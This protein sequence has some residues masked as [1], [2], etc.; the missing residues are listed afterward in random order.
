LEPE[1]DYSSYYY[2]NRRFLDAKE[3]MDIGA[4]VNWVLEYEDKGYRIK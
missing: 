4:I 1:D 3:R 2:R